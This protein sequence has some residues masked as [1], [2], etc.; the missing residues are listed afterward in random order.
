MSKLYET[1][2]YKDLSYAEAYK[3]MKKGF[4]ATRPEW[5]GFHF[6]INREYYIMLKDKTIIA[7]PKEVQGEALCDWMLVNPTQEAIEVLEQNGIYL[8]SENEEQ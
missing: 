8:I 5:D 7:N 3:M 2:P 4:F 1:T 6:V